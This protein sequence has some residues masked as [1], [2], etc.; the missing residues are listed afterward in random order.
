M[1]RFNS[2]TENTLVYRPE[3][4]IN[5]GACTEVCP[6]GVFS[7][8]EKKP[9]LSAKENCMECGACML[10]CPVDAISVESGAGCAYGLMMAAITGNSQCE[11]GENNANFSPGE[12]EEDTCKKSC[13][14]K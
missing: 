10:N 14:G 5:C 9:L 4:C 1:K 3:K 12:K 2:Y 11:C 6:H 8:G 7:K 13:C